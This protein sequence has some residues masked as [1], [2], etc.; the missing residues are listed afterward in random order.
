MDEQYANSGQSL[1]TQMWFVIVNLAALWGLGYVF[2]IPYP[3][4]LLGT[5]GLL[6]FTFLSQ[7]AM[8]RRAARTS[9]LT[10]RRALAMLVVIPLLSSPVALVVV[11]LGLHGW[12]PVA[13]YL[14]VLA[15][16]NIVYF[17]WFEEDGGATS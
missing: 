17:L 6:F 2:K 8:N 12:L 11:L 1:R 15:V 14:A 3:F 13:I 9:W 7:V 16:L 4:L 5:G 10:G